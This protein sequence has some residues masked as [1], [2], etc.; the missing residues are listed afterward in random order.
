MNKRKIAKF[1]LAD[2]RPGVRAKEFNQ[3]LIAMT[4]GI[5]WALVLCTSHCKIHK[6]KLYTC[7]VRMLFNASQ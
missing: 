7:T 3:L 5:P 4:H 2:N 1:L 6:L